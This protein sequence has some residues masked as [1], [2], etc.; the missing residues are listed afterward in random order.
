MR[1]KREKERESRGGGAVINN[2]FGRGGAMTKNDSKPQPFFDLS[3]LRELVHSLRAATSISY[4][5]SSSC[6]ISNVVRVRS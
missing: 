6:F 3:R 4:Y 2:P 1:Q 5:A